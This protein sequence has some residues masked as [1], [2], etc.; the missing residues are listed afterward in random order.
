M[1]KAFRTFNARTATSWRRW[2]S[3][4]ALIAISASTLTPVLAQDSTSAP[5][6]YQAGLISESD[7]AV[8]KQALDASRSRNFVFAE[9]LR[10]SLSDPV[11]RKLVQ[12]SIV[13]NDGDIYGFA[14]LDGARRDLWGWP[15]E[16]KR[17]IA[18]EKQI[19]TSSLTPQQTIEWFKG[20]PPLSVD[21]AIAL[22][23]AYERAGQT[24]E[25]S[26]LAKSWWRDQAF[27][28]TDQTRFQASFGRYLTA[29]DHQARLNTLLLGTQGPATNAMLPLV[30]ETSRKVATA[31]M[32]LRSGSAAGVTL[33]E[34]ALAVSPRN[35][36]LAYE[37]LRSLRRAKLETLGFGLLADLPAAPASE[38]AINNL[39][40]E[41]LSYYRAALKARN[42]Q[43]AYTAMNGGGFPNGE[44]KAEGEFFAGW[45]ALIRLNRPDLAIAHFEKVREAGT[46]PI[47]RSRAHYWLGRAYE[48]RNQTG[49]AEKAH[50]HFVEGGQFIYAFY[51]QLAAEKAGIKSITLGKDPVPTDADR[52]R[53]D[54]RDMV[55]AA[56]ILGQTGERDLFNALVLALDDV[57][58][59]AEEQAL[60]VD[61]AG[62]YGTQDLSMRVARVSQ[63]RGFYLPERAYPLRALPAVKS[64]EGSFVLAITRQE[65]GF[66]PMVR[67]SANAR[68][69]MQLI[70]PTA[71]GVAR[72]MSLT[73]SD[74]MLYEADYNMKLGAY[75][76]GELVDRFG[77]SYVMAAAGY[78]A[79]PNRPP[80]WIIDCGDP[81]GDAADPIAFIECAPFTETRNYMMRVMENNA[82]YRA[83]LNGGTAPLTPMADL[84]RGVIV[85][86]TPMTGDSEDTGSLPT[87]PINYNE[88]KSTAGN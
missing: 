10:G 71:R 8:L 85:A 50:A 58:P 42:Y 28:L 80:Q 7:K 62:T 15:R 5:R 2:M 52:A 24:A 14:A 57:L 88:L 20:A 78:N 47:T 39:W 40:V 17:Q 55:K 75:H 32:A 25:A 54:N 12:W 16:Q 31:A 64:P 84:K 1:I 53:F 22:I 34:Q 61:L 46:S 29:E 73:Y 82:V 21:G 81:R 18:A 43:A 23:G 51:G 38:A 30:D 60:L 45:A 79:G 36:V 74:S 59:T 13:N 4:V 70:P 77:G 72:R 63:Q 26:A 86:Y 33:Y 41:R 48:A 65:S 37:R 27:D 9:S 76:L 11:A 19:I 67:S 83:R 56:K 3:G 66:D 49:D 87:G 69:M 6:P 44:K 35:P 68:G